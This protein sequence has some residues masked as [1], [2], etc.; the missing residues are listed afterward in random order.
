MKL[1]LATRF[2]GENPERLTALTDFIKQSSPLVEEVFVIS[3]ESMDRINAE[4]YF[5]A[6]TFPK[7]HFS[8]LD[9]WGRYTPALNA[10]VYH[11]ASEGFSHVIMCS[12]EI[13]LTKEILESLARHLDED[14]L[15]VGA[16][17]AGHEFRAGE[18]TGSGATTPWN[19]L[20]V[21]NLRYL[22][23]T[24]FALMGDSP[25]DPEA[26]GV[27]EVATCAVLQKLYPR[28]LV[29]LVDVGPVEWK[30]ADLSGER[31]SR[32]I[33]KIETKKDRAGRQLKSMELPPPK[34]LHMGK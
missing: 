23:R 13:G 25:Q 5:A 26:A 29:K 9:M 32:H 20:A 30:I 14:T 12:V 27:E 19:T 1:A 17:L 2:F 24:G 3:N 21:W 10:I 16:R 7:T 4:G 18:N 11:T 15:V 8:S 34:V 28:L 31:I 33:K 22:S 6:K